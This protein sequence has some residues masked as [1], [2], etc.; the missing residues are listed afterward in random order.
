L[1]YFVFLSVILWFLFSTLEEVTTKQHEK[2]RKNT[3]NQTDS[4]PW[5]RPADHRFDGDAGKR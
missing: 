2:A 1:I 4:L 3:K 5:E